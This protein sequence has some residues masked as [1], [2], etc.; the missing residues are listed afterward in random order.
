VLIP[1]PLLRGQ[2]RGLLRARLRAEQDGVEIGSQTRQGEACGARL[3]FP[4]RGQRALGIHTGAVGLSLGV[5]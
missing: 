3:A 4:T 5:T 2:L 1:V